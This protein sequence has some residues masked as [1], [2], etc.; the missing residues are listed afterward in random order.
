MK[1]LKQITAFVLLVL[2]SIPV[3]SPFVLQLQQLYVQ[4]EME[5]ALE[6]KQLMIVRVHSTAV[7]WIHKNKEC[8]IDGKMFDVKSSAA[9][10]SS[11][12][13]LTGLFDEHEKQIKEQISKQTRGLQNTQSKQIAKANKI[14]SASS[15][16]SG[17]E[18]FLSSIPTQQQLY[19]P[20][21][22]KE[23]YA[24]KLAPPPKL[25]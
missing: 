6:K 1:W 12:V 3:L 21:F 23:P 13:A 2:F 10:G 5:E 17:F 7:K 11:Y 8:L 14:V 19:H 4:H 15:N 16:E 9:E 24:G 22:Y 25:V 20:C 18:V